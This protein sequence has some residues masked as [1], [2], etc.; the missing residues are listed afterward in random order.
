MLRCPGSPRVF[1]FI[2]SGVNC[3]CERSR[4]V[5]LAIRWNRI[6]CGA[7]WARPG[8]GAR[9]GHDVAGVPRVPG[10]KLPISVAL[11]RTVNG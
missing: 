2:C 1:S 4:M 3:E 11:S 9:C 5:S 7:M 8:G 10:V 6:T